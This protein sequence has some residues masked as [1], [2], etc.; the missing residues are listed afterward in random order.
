[1]SLEAFQHFLAVKR[2]VAV[3]VDGVENL[4]QFFL[5]VLVGEVTGDESECRLLE[6]LVALRLRIIAFNGRVQF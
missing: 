6:L 4:L 2:A 5:L 1:V 3:G